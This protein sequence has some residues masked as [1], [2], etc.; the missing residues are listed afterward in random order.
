MSEVLNDIFVLYRSCARILA[1]IRVWYDVSIQRRLSSSWWIWFEYWRLGLW[2][3][4]ALSEIPTTSKYQ[5]RFCSSFIREPGIQEFK[6]GTRN[7]K[8]RATD[9]IK[10]LTT[11]KKKSS[12]NCSQIL[13]HWLTWLKSS[14]LQLMLYLSNKKLAAE[15]ACFSCTVGLSAPLTETFSIIFTTRSVTQTSPRNSTDHVLALRQS[16]KE[17]TLK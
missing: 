12:A 8:T 3:L 5:V 16:L 9:K 4:G 10:I 13:L 15:L 6:L 17:H 14:E 7:H 1:G 11:T 2:G